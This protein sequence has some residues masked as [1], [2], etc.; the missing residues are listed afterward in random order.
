MSEEGSDLR[1][2]QDADREDTKLSVVRDTNESGVMEE[3]DIMG[4]SL[5]L[6]A[7]ECQRL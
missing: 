5:K 7:F 2:S 1:K 4:T 3:D 6:C